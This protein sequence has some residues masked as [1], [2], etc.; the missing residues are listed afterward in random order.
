MF[1]LSDKKDKTYN[2]LLKTN[3]KIKFFNLKR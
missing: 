3:L 1:Y 2:F